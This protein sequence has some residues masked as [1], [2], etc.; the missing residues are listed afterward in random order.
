ML[1]RPPLRRSLVSAADDAEDAHFPAVPGFDENIVPRLA[2]AAH[3]GE[4]RA[5]AFGADLRG[6]R[7]Y[8]QQIALV[9]GNIAKSGKRRL[10]AKKLA[11]LCVGVI[12]LKD[13]RIFRMPG[14]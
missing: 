14:E 10:L 11:D 5:K 1:S 8:F 7:Q 12:H 6:F 13:A 2:V 4:W 9:E 3:I